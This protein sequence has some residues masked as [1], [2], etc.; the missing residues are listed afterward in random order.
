MGEG[1]T[2]FQIITLHVSNFE[3][4]FATYT[5]TTFTK[6]IRERKEKFEEKFGRFN[7]VKT[8]SNSLY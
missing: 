6:S 8:D 4:H 5:E 1:G 7:Y 3:G 2:T